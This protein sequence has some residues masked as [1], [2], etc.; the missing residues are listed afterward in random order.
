MERRYRVRLGELLDDAV[1]PASLLRGVLPRLEDFL[2]PFV[3]TLQTP[4]RQ[5]NARHYVQGLLSDLNGKD[6]ES[7]AYLHDRERQGLQKFIGQADWMRRRCWPNW[8]AKWRPSWVK[9]TACWFS[10]PRPF[11]RRG[12]RR[13]GCG[14]SGV[15]DSAR[16]T[17]AR[18]ASISAMFRA[19]NTRSWIFDFTCPRN[20]PTASVDDGGPGCRRRSA[21]ARGMNRCWKCWTNAVRFCRT[22][23]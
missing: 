4:E 22:P 23:G 11:P 6:V 3:A 5:I 17:T 16:S 2:Q 15:A 12:P 20:G 7:I 1:V 10:I 21:S 8:Y 18:W 13:W 19:A 9:P 14:G